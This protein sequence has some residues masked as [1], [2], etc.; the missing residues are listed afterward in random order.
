[1]AVLV[2][3]VVVAAMG[4]WPCED[5]P[6]CKECPPPC[7]PPVE[8]QLSIQ[9]AGSQCQIVNANGNASV[10]VK[11][12]EW[13]VWTN[14]VGRNV[15]LQFSATQ[16]LFGV[17]TAIVYAAGDPLKLQLR[18]DAVEGEFAYKADCGTPYPGPIIIIPPPGP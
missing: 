8:H 15:R 18:K 13:V 1:V 7:P 17:E 5:C 3:I 14:S 6:I 16:K 4:C 2:A 10:S 12:G 9:T 11:Q